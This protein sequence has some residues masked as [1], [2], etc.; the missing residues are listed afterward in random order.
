MEAISYEFPTNQQTRKFLRLEQLF[1]T[2]RGLVELTDSNAQK[3]ALFRLVEI[4]DFFER[5]DVRGE[6]LKELDRL[7][8]SMNLLL[9]NPAVDSSKLSYFVTQLE[10]LNQVLSAESRAGDKLRN[11]PMITLARQKWSLGATFCAFD[12]PAIAHFV[13]SGSEV[14]QSHL[15]YW[16]E[17]IKVYRTSV[18]VILRLYRESGDFQNFITQNLCYQEPIDN[19]VKLIGI[20][21]PASISYIPEVSAGAHRVCLQLKPSQWKPSKLNNDPHESIE[22]QFALAKYR[23]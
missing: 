20:K 7:Q 14:T 3:I 4:M 13:A 21:I 17:L 9:N 19:K 8:I 5:N 1:K 22:I 10:K 16:L 11:E 6:L 23:A 18:N 12:S 2:I 15:K